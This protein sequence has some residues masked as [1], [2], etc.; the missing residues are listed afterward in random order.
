MR[1]SQ[2]H[3]L[4]Q[5][6]P[7]PVAYHRP[8]PFRPLS[9]HAGVGRKCTAPH[10]ETKARSGSALLLP[11][12]PLQH[13]GPCRPLVSRSHALK[14]TTGLQRLQLHVM[15]VSRFESSSE[16]AAYPNELSNRKGTSK[17]KISRVALG[18]EN[19]MRGCRNAGANFRSAT[20]VALNAEPLPALG[21]AA[22]KNTLTLLGGHPAAKAMA[23]L[24]P[25]IAGVVSAFRHLFL[26]LFCSR[27]RNSQNARLSYFGLMLWI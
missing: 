19:R 11:R 16:P 8:G 5:A 12:Q 18:S 20:R 14:F 27:D 7:R 26:T 13:E 4:L 23:A 1:R 17:L 2:T 24:A 15:L 6:S 21:P 10:R 3:G 22:G 9:F 25:Q